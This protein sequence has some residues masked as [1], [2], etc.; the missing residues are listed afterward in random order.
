M[1]ESLN[2]LALESPIESPLSL[3]DV[4]VEFDLRNLLNATVAPREPRSSSVVR[5]EFDWRA[6]SNAETS[7]EVMS[8]T[9]KW[10]NH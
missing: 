4:R 8:L 10:V 6:Q 2:A 1:R 3:S 7:D 9:S 5:V